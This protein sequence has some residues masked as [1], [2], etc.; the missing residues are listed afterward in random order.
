MYL[1]SQLAREQ[2]AVSLSGDGGDELFGGYNRYRWGSA[3]S[4][5]IEIYPH[6][7]RQIGAA[8]LRTFS[9]KN[10]DQ[11][12]SIV[13]PLVP[14]NF[15]QRLPGEKV[16]KLAK[17]LE[18]YKPEDLYNS[19][20][21]IWSNP[22]S[23]ICKGGEPPLFHDKSSPWHRA[24]I[25]TQMMR[26]DLIGYLPDDILVKVDRAAMALSLETR[27]PFLDFR[28]AEFAGRLPLHM[29]IRAGQGKWILRQLL[30]KSVPRELVERP[31]M[32]FGVPIDSWLRG[33]LRDWAEALLDKQRLSREGYL[34]AAPIRQ[35]WVEHLSGR[36][37]WQ[38]QLWCVLMFQ[39]WLENERC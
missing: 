9:P 20:V 33:P 1:V 6:A 16:H 35:K 4:A 29:K 5:C 36:K 3:L 14:S 12:F 39:S 19:L 38:H 24:T 8:L 26:R 34:Q 28:V 27:I 23:I 25:A 2:V 15:Q 22:Q 10:W 37:N 31:K 18:C 30:Y 13:A 32:G 7:L 11:I 17:L 21:S